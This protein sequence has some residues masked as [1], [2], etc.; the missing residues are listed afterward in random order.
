MIHVIF[1]RY[2]ENCLQNYCSRRSHRQTAD[3]CVLKS[4]SNGSFHDLSS[5]H[6]NETR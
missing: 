2:S 5:L 1:V 3:N 4:L 6:V